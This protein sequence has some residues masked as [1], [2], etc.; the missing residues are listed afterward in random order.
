MVEARER[1]SSAE[2]EEFKDENFIEKPAILDKYKAAAQITNAALL[3]VITLCVPGADINKVCQEGDAFIE[4]ELKKIFNNKKSKK[5]ERGIAFPTCVSVNNICGHFS[6]M[7]DESVSLQE[8]DIAKIDLGAHLD[9]FIAQAAHTIV[10]SADASSKVD[11]KKADVILAAY[12]ATLAAQRIIKEGSTNSQVTEAIAK[13][14][15]SFGV[16]PLEGVLSH[17]VKKH[18]IDGNDVIINKETPEQRVEEFEFAPG[19]V[20]GLD[21]YVS[22]GEGKPRESEF[23]TTVFKRELDTQYNLK[24]QKSRAFFTEVNKRFPTLPFAIRAFEDPIGAKVGVKECIDHDLMTGYPVLT[25][26]AGEFVAHFKTTVA[27]LPR[28]TVVLAGEVPLAARYNSE[29]K[30]TDADRS[31]LIAGELWK[32][33][34]KKK[35]AATKKEDEKKQ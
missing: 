13:V 20:I 14:C 8:G 12:N 6:P 24:L 18:L 22:S 7:A 34:D 16:N 21:I 17:K 2:G 29:K 35:G 1:G 30:V 3:K 28:S 26:K 15:E 5:L 31:A 4:E 10:V 32:K 25:E 33:E 27:V 11:G 19:D 23:R 9:G